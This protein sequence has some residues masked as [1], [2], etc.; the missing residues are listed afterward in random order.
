VRALYV[1][2]G[3]RKKT[4]FWWH[5]VCDA[6][7]HKTL[8]DPRG[9]AEGPSGQRTGWLRLLVPFPPSFLARPVSLKTPLEPTKQFTPLLGF[10]GIFL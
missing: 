7:E 4:G 5:A 9:D 6:A 2:R 3:D 8:P 1:G 10:L